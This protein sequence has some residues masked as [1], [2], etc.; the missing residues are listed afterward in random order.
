MTTRDAH[1]RKILNKELTTQFRT[2]DVVK[3]KGEAIRKRM[4]K[5]ADSYVNKKKLLSFYDDASAIIDK[6]IAEK[7]GIEKGAL[8]GNSKFLNSSL[9]SQL[10]AVL[11]EFEKKLS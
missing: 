3:K 6:L 10:R 1:F 5:I 4:K 8:K 2:C 11:T 9:L 7:G